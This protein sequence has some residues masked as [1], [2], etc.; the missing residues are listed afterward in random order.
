MIEFEN[1]SFAYPGGPLLLQGFSLRAAPG[2]RIYFTG[3]SGCG[4]TTALRLLLSLEKPQS[5][6]VRVPAHTKFSVVFQEDRLLPQRTVWENLAL[7]AGKEKLRPLLAE[8]GI[9][10]AAEQLPAELSGGMKRRAALARALLAPFDVLVLDEPFTGLDEENAGRALACIDRFCRN[11]TLFLVT[12]E[13]E[14]AEALACRRVPLSAAEN[15]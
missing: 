15:K 8:L 9:E 3:P 2:E 12:H 11:K 10:A 6:A 1:V 13:P 7:F 4:K 5:G 14:R